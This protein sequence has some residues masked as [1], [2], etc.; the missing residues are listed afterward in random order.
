MQRVQLEYQAKVAIDNFA[1][2]LASDESDAE[3]W[4]RASRIGK[5]LGSKRISRYC[6]EAALELD[7]D[8]TVAE[9]EPPSLE[10]AFAGEQLKRLLRLLSDETSLSH[11][12]L[13]PFIKKSLPKLLLRHIDPYPFLPNTTKDL[14]QDEMEVIEPD[15]ENRS[16]LRVDGRTWTIVGDALCEAFLSPVGQG[17]NAIEIVLPELAQSIEQEPA[18]AIEDQTDENVVMGEVAASPDGER[19]TTTPAAASNEDLPVHIITTTSTV[20]LADDT[21]QTTTLPTRKRSQSV[22]GLQEPPEEDTGMQKRSKR[23]RKR[24]TTEGPVDPV[25]QY[26]E[27]LKDFHSADEQ[28]FTFV[29]TVLKKLGV[30]DL[31][32]FASL[33]E[34]LAK[35]E[36]EDRQD[37]ILN[38]AVRD[39]RDI[40]SSWDDAKASTFINA[41]AADMLGSTSGSANTGVTAFL[42]HSQS[43][44]LKVS[45]IP[46]HSETEGVVDFSD[47][48]NTGWFP[49]QDAIYE[50]LRQVLPT[51]KSWRWSDEM[52]R[53]VARIVSFT[54]SELFARNRFELKAAQKC[55]NAKALR[56][57]EE[58]TQTVVELHLDIYARVTGPNSTVAHETR[59]M[60]KDRVERWLESAAS[61]MKQREGDVE[62]DLTL[63]YLWTSVYYSTVADSVSRDHKV[64]CWSDLQT[65]L[66]DT[67]KETVEL[68][69]SVVMPEISATA[70]EREVSRLTTLDFFFNL[71]QADRSEPFAIIETLEPVLDPGSALETSENESEVVNEAERLDKTP[72]VLREMWRF[73]KTGS[74][75]LRLFLWQRLREAY[76][77]IGYNT[78]VFSCHLKCIEVIVADIRSEDFIDSSAE[79]RRHK[80]LKWLKTLDDLLVKSL[81]IALNDASTCFE[82]ID[83]RH[84]KSTCAA[85]A[86]LNRVLHTA[87]LFDDEIKVGMKQLPANPAFAAGGTFQSFTNK[88]REMQVRTWSLQY[89]LVKEA[90]TQNLDLFPTPES[91]LADYLA[92]VHYSLGL[93]RSC[94]SSNK[95]FLKMMKV[96]MIRFKNIERWEDYLGQVLFDLYGL[97]LG[98]GTYLLD[99]HGCPTENIDRRTVLN[100]MDQV[101]QLANRIPMKDLLKHDLRTTIE[102]MQTAV[103]A[104]KETTQMTHNSRNFTE[105]LKTSIR[106]INFVKAWRGQITLDSVP[107]HTA[108]SQMAQQ[109]WYFLLGMINLAKFRSQKRGNYGTPIDDLQVAATFLRIQLQ[110]DANHWETWYRLAQCYDLELEEEVLWST[111]KLNN[112]KSEII[113]LQRSSIHCYVMALSMAMQYADASAGTAEKLSEFYFDFGMRIYASLREPF[114]M[115]AF[116]MDDFEKH[117]SGAQGMYKKLLHEEM[118]KFRAFSQAARLFK[119][120]LVDSPNKWM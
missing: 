98:V 57:L 79:P 19:V 110:F 77:N 26:A 103:G 76:S 28:V 114:S 93:R 70:A 108:D 20:P 96:E 43:G 87:A 66:K 101:I 119:K 16:R 88:L 11:P 78:K 65:F 2:A 12:I 80:L 100:I 81:T 84:I 15:L 82:I 10:E 54:D 71:F 49:L 63:R 90:M 99:D 40:L 104:T 1:L 24:D 95:I 68:P 60:T 56:V 17:G 107:V 35:P 55:G 118:S 61:L 18:A 115:E 29:G 52:K 32:T 37:A 50:W 83:E 46:E 4:R 21:A 23:I 74:T 5:L 48:I 67:E 91:D 13:A 47:M 42:E 113:K 109:G 31:D 120:A 86:Q 41:N 30:E 25:A 6:L 51:Y 3:L 34:V 62:D 59:I 39:L 64:L 27:Q 9:V 97:K 45:T 38:T 111:D 58:I 36:A 112:H 94:R 105:Y 44:P 116:Y 8:P 72:A 85:I 106:P 89:T 117:M 75:S 53:C 69:N 92:L 33:Q 7:D 22:A 14:Q 102:K 73:L